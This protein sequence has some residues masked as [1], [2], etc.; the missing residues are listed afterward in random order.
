MNTFKRFITALA[1]ALGTLSATGAAHAY[2]DPELPQFSTPKCAKK[3]T[4][5]HLR[6]PR[7][8]A[9][10][11]RGWFYEKGRYTETNGEVVRWILVIG[12][13]GKVWVDTQGYMEGPR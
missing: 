1:L 4:Y 2:A 3:W 9:C 8:R 11:A 5:N 10:K 6:S 12:P 13:K 7:A